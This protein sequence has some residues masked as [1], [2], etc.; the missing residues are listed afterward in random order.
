MYPFSHT[1]LT[2]LLLFSLHVLLLYYLRTHN[3][4][5]PVKIYILFTHH[6]TLINS[7]P[8]VLFDWKHLLLFFTLYIVR[9]VI[10][11]LHFFFLLS[12]DP[13]F[14]IWFLWLRSDLKQ[15]YIPW[16]NITTNER[17]VRIVGVLFFVDGRVWGRVFFSD[18]WNNGW[19]NFMCISLLGKEKYVVYRKSWNWR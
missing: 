16:I 7:T 17:G 13:F 5:D 11:F 1:I 8:T 18:D 14:F 9:V 2:P 3:F 15:I 4:R 6:V 10:K 12:F 19:Y